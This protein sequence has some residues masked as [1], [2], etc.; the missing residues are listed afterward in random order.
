[1]C[2]LYA[3]LTRGLQARL[4]FHHVD[5]EKVKLN[6]KQLLEQIHNEGDNEDKMLI[7]VIAMRLSQLDQAGDNQKCILPL[8][9]LPLTYV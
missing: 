6:L 7:P 2:D 3:T 1:L 5:Q 8:M 4:A 9:L